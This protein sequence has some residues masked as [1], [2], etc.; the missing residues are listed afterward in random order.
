MKG[1]LEP[2]NE[3]GRLR[4]LRSYDILDSLSEEEF[5]RLTE[6]ASIICET[7]ISLVSLVDSSR[8]WFK[9]KVG[10][11]V[12][13][14]PRS[15]AFCNYPVQSNSFLEVADATKDERFQNNLLVTGNPK[16]RFYAGYPL[17]DPEGYTLGTLCVIDT[18]P[19]VLSATQKRALELL[20]NEVMGLIMERRQKEELKNFEKLFGLSNDLICVAG[21]DG[22]FKKI[23]P[24]FKE[25]LG[26]DDTK[27]LTTPFS[28]LTHPD[29]VAE[30]QRQ[31]EKLKLGEKTVDFTTRLKTKDQ[32]YKTIQWEGTPEPATG[33]LF[34][35]GRDISIQKAREIAL[36]DSESRLK[37]FFQNS[38][39]LMCTHDL[40]GRFLSVNSAGANIIGYSVDELLSM[41]LFDIIPEERHLMLE[42]YLRVVAT[43]GIARGQMVTRGKNGN[44]RI[45][46]FNNVLEESQSGDSYVIGNAVDITEKQELENNLQRTKEML[47]RTNQVARVG[48]WQLDFPERHIYW[49]SVTKEIHGLGQDYIPDLKSGI[50]FYKEGE[51]RT[52]I[53]EAI[54]ECLKTGKPWDIELQIVNKKGEDVWVRT[55][56]NAVF[57]NGVCK[58]MYGTFQD[59]NDSKKAQLEIKAAKLAAEEANL[60]KS[61]F[62]ANMSHEIRTPLNGIIGFTDLVLKTELNPAQQQYLKIVNQSGSA[63]LS[64]VNDILDF[65]K[66]E[67]GKL[68]LD[69]VKSDLY[70][71]SGQATDIIKYQIEHKGLEMMLRIAQGVPRFVWVDDVRLRQVLINL[72]GNAV[73]FT[74]SGE[75]ELS[76][77]FIS[78]Y[79][80][81]QVFRFSV[82]DTGIG[83]HPEKLGKIFEAFSQE[84][85]STTKKYGGT[86]LGLTISNSLLGLMGSKLQLRSSP[87]EGSTFFFDLR[88][89]SEA[90]DIVPEV[91]ANF[92]VLEP[93]ARSLTV[94]IAEDNAINMLLARTLLKRIAPNA[95]IVEAV[96]GAEAVAYCEIEQPDIIFMDVQMPEM[97]GY[98]ASRR[99]R[100]MEKDMHI[101]IIALTAG[102]EKSEREKCIAAGMDDFVVKPVVEETIAAV[103]NKW[104]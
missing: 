64:I 91:D 89:K 58:R 16:I 39:G 56:G 26:W 82:R 13:E 104:I 101:P 37:I 10:L 3:Q 69:I 2:A 9:S 80:L 51:S 49:T 15:L 6:L 93:V 99:I 21:T 78:T 8:Q 22:Y 48:G 102:N 31:L 12:E 30:T 77:Q 59:I 97:N 84:D 1:K 23:N 38:Q 81:E 65:S 87:G 57:E 103:F 70:E 50:S 95:K 4:A 61:E 5:D 40:A 76:I 62:L 18:K 86:G 14:T 79:D 66:I 98:E 54:N 42:E 7:P 68:E 36:A 17:T 29:D 28:E 88:L 74:E 19:R 85:G 32:G 46:M 71:L 75:I 55:I 67:A 41:S 94:L 52:K 11:D 96:D 60:A 24:A 73:K 44:L 34:A 92:T 27:I 25:I 53:T 20:A 100:I 63:L 47:E 33:F 43:Q 45:W 83:I 35:V 90:G 72:L